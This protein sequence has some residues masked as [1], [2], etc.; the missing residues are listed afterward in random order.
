MAVGTMLRRRLRVVPSLRSPRPVRPRR[1]AHRVSPR[2][3]G[4]PLAVSVSVVR[5]HL[6]D[7]AVTLAV[8]RVPTLLDS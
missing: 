5:A 6:L 2:F 1:R 8:A 3:R 7:A 4:P